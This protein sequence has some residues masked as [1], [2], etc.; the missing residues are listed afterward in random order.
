M[1]NTEIFSTM[2]QFTNSIPVW[3]LYNLIL[4]LHLSLINHIV[5]FCST[6]FTWLS[7][8]VIKALLHFLLGMQGKVNGRESTQTLQACQNCQGKFLR[9][10]LHFCIPTCFIQLRTVTGRIYPMMTDLRHLKNI[11]AFWHVALVEKLW[12]IWLM[13]EGCKF[14]G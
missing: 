5:Y 10:K 1:Q 3:W 9:E 7:R 2:R 13:W 11:P 14:A 8:T 12:H 4:T 6:V